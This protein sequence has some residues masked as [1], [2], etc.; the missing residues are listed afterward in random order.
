LLSLA[1]NEMPVLRE[2]TT[3]G[4]KMKTW[5]QGKYNALV[6]GAETKC[7]KGAAYQVESEW[8]E[9]ALRK[10]E[11]SA[12]EVVRCSIEMDDGT[13]EGCTFRFVGGVD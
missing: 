9:D 7:I 13:V 2:A 5:G 8:H 10:Y 12:Y 6:D 3:R 4:G 1:E 11:T